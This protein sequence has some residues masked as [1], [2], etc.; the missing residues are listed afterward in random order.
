MRKLGDSWRKK[1]ADQ[2]ISVEFSVE[3]ELWEWYLCGVKINGKKGERNAID[4][5]ITET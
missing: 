3:Y 5:F 2:N 4:A 1:I